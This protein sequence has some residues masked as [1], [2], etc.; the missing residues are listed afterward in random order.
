MSSKGKVIIAAPVHKVL[1]D[2]LIAA[3]YTCEVH[4]HIT[5]SVFHFVV[6]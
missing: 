6:H 1:I 4:E 2:G 5:L 3:G